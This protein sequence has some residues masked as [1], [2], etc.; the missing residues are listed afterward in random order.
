MCFVNDL[1][2]CFG[3]P[4]CVDGVSGGDEVIKWL[5]LESWKLDADRSKHAV[6]QILESDASRD[7]LDAA[8]LSE[9]QLAK[10][11]KFEADRLTDRRLTVDRSTGRSPLPTKCVQPEVP[12]Y[13]PNRNCTTYIYIYIYIYIMDVNQNTQWYH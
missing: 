10:V 7:T 3:Q 1:N 5:E 6:N 4:R 2:V 8:T 12:M 11:I 13:T 9:D